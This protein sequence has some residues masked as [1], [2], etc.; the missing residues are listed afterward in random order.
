M[1]DKKDGHLKVEITINGKNHHTD[2]GKNAVEELRRLAEVPPAEVLCQLKD[3]KYT[4]LGNEEHIEIHGGEVFAS[5]YKE[6]PCPEITINGKKYHT[7]AGRNS[8]EHLRHLGHVPADEILSE[9]K[10]GKFVDLDNNAHVE[11]HGGEVF[12]SHVQSG[13]SS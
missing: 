4:D 3:G 11:I 12:A 1:N 10:H 9:F 6:H 8:V 5:H 7:H 2:R 13:G